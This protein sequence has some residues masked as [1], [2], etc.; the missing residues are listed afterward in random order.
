MLQFWKRVKDKLDY[1]DL[2]QK[3]LAEKIH[4]SY[5]T[6][7]SWINRNRLPNAEQAVKIA[8]AL[9]TSVEFLVTGTIKNKPSNNAKTIKLLEDAI[10]N[11][12]KSE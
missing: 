1:H 2:T 5:N 3:E 9:E 6:L 11:L 7:Q 8:D 12:R 4:E 10:Q